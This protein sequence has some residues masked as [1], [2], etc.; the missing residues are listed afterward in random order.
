VHLET[1]CLLQL[2]LLRLLCLGCDWRLAHCSVS[3]VQV[4]C[5]GKKKGQ[6]VD[7]PARA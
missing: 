3:A 6:H 5:G 1:L 7:Q 4:F 2:L